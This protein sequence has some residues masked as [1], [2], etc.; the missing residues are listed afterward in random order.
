MKI[1]EVCVIVLRESLLMWEI[2]FQLLD[3]EAIL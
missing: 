2:P 3:P 1:W